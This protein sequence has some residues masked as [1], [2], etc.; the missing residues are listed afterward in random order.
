[1]PR[2]WECWE[3]KGLPIG[4]WYKEV[5]YHIP[6]TMPSLWFNVNKPPLDNPELRRA[7]AYCIDYAKISELAMSNYS[8]K[9]EASLIVPY[10]AQAKYFN[11]EL[12]KQEGWEYKDVYKR[13]LYDLHL[14]LIFYRH[15]SLSLCVE[16]L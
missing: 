4:T 12:V 15:P 2:I 9:V 8:P 3:N 7:I 14:R 6:A 11:K 16:L 13:Q 10:G 5:P 1:M